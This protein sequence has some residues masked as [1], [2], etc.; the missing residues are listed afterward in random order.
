MSVL[1]D[2][3][4]Q[5]AEAA[6]R[7]EDPFG[8]VIYSYTRAQAIADGVLVDIS[9]LWPKLVEEAGIKMPLAMTCTAFQTVVGPISS[10]GL[11]ESPL[12]EGQSYEGRLWD[13]LFVF[14]T[15]AHAKPD[16]DRVHFRVS[17]LNLDTHKHETVHLWGHCGQGDNGE[18]VLTLMLEDED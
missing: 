17:V 18:A 2:L 3:D 5:Q 7:K 9:K 8:P 10:K 13:V 6:K 15:V 4:Q 12:P 14:R 11:K 16:S 1:T